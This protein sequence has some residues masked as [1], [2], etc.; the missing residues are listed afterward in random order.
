MSIDGSDPD[1]G[2]H[3]DGEET[4]DNSVPTTDEDMEDWLIDNE[5]A[6][7]DARGSNQS[8]MPAP[9]DSEQDFQDDLNKA[10][11]VLKTFSKKGFFM[12][13][14]LTLVRRL[15]AKLACDLTSNI[16]LRAIEASDLV[17]SRFTDSL[18]PSIFKSSLHYASI[19][20]ASILR[21]FMQNRP[22]LYDLW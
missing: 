12:I 21:A 5:E 3:A 6:V 17:N 9:I 7:T 16:Y 22:T 14:D 2:I 11:E 19:F 8:P 15:D 13:R 1:N 20:R 4:L 10:W 18:I